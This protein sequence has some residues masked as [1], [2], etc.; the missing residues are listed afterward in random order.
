MKRTSLLATAL[1]ALGLIFAATGCST[2]FTPAAANRQITCALIVSVSGGGAP[3]DAQWATMQKNFAALLEARGLVLVTDPTFADKLIQ[4]LFVPDA[5][6]PNTGVSYIVGIRNNPGSMLATVSPSLPSYS[7]SYNNFPGFSSFGFSPQYYGYFTD[8][9][10]TEP[11]VPVTSGPT[12]P[13]H[14]PNPPPNHP[15]GGHHVTRPVDCPPDTTPHRPTPGYAG[16]RPPPSNPP[17]GGNHWWNRHPSS[18]SSSS[19]YSSSSYS[20]SSNF[21]GPSSSY[22]SSSSNSSPSISFPSSSSSS[23]YSEPVQMSS[24]PSVSDSSSRSISFPEKPL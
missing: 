16:N 9:S 7:Y 18:D 1:L 5:I 20:S 13:S 11:Y 22:S 19:G 17:D 12:P 6:D 24:P 2:L 23:S 8:Y 21:V 3:T 14:R 4:V 15:G 10:Y